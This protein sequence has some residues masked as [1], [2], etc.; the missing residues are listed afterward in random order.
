MIVVF[1]I[2]KNARRKRQNASKG[3]KGETSI[4][5]EVVAETQA[6]ARYMYTC[7]VASPVYK[8]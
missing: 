4:T 3:K 7:M 2:A 6:I 8:I 5:N 1:K